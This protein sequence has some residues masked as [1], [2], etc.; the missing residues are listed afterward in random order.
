MATFRF[1]LGFSIT[2][3][4]TSGALAANARMNGITLA[5]RDRKRPGMNKPARSPATYLPHYRGGC[6]ILWSGQSFGPVNPGGGANGLHDSPA[7][8]V[9]ICLADRPERYSGVRKL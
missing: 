8:S 1:V 2:W 5:D 3:P 6:D 9:G 7:A 4:V